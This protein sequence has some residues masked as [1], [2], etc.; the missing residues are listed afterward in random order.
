[1]DLAQLQQQLP[2]LEYYCERLYNAQVSHVFGCSGL[3]CEVIAHE[4]SWAGAVLQDPNERA[5]AEQSLT[6]FAKSTDYIPHLRVR[7]LFLLA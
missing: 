5:Q 6:P 7:S 4:A 2:Q 3:Y 1:M